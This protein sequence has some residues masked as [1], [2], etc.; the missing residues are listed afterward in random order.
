MTPFAPYC[1][2]CF[3]PLDEPISGAQVAVF[4][5]VAAAAPS[6]ALQPQ[7]TAASF[8][9]RSAPM[10]APPTGPIPR[11]VPRPVVNVLAS[12]P[13][14]TY[15]RKVWATTGVAVGLGALLQLA[16]FQH[17][18]DGGVAPAKLIT[19]SLLAT[20]AL[21]L[22]VLVAVVFRAWSVEHALAPHWSI[23]SRLGSV[24]LGASAG[25]I[26]AGVLIL[27][28]K[29][30]TG[31]A[32]TDDGVSLL[33]GERDPARTLLAVLVIVVGAPI[34]EEL[35][36]RGLLLEG[37][38][39]RG[40]KVAVGASAAAFSVW[41]LQPAQF[42]Y[43]AVLGA[44]LGLLYL[45]RGLVASMS[46]HAAFNGLLVVVAI[47]VAAGP[48]RTVEANGVTLAAPGQWKLSDPDASDA[49]LDG[50]DLALDG[51][52]GAGLVIQHEEVPLSMQLT[53]ELLLVQ[54]RTTGGFFSG[55]TVKLASARVEELSVGRAVRL[56]VSADGQGGQL[57]VLPLGTRVWTI[58]LLDSGS[59]RARADFAQM[60]PTLRLPRARAHP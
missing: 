51:P 58:V 33:V 45:K 34:V 36:F 12:A 9:P 17:G 39:D 10:Y 24:V 38:R 43:Y 18:R 27:I 19:Y 23:G 53:P 37:L 44:L 3:A 30:T 7:P 32:V 6:V 35:L 4:A 5:S 60:L 11:G 52:S 21:Y 1:S 26:L 59:Q 15:A 41:H 20:A 40:K 46:A 28:L 56:D 47:A 25:V 29:A 50:V 49:E 14:P 2:V 22:L 55:L 8:P 13:S 57:I 42:R 31:E 54:L 16:L 48:P